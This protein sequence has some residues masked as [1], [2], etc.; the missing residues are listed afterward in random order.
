LCVCVCV[1]FQ[2]LARDIAALRMDAPGSVD[3]EKFKGEYKIAKGP[4]SS[5]PVAVGEAVK[6]MV[7]YAFNVYIYTFN[8]TLC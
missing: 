8:I 5:S 4:K 1:V 2:A 6:E 3:L 7:V